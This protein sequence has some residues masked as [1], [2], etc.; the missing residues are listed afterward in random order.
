[1]I[2]V[3]VCGGRR[4]DGVLPVLNSLHTERPI[5]LVVHGGAGQVVDGKTT[6]AD[7][8]A[9]LWARRNQVN[10][11]RVPAKWRKLG[12]PAGMIRNREMLE[13]S[14]SVVVDLVVAF[15]GGV[16]TADMVSRARAAGIHVMEI[17]S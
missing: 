12:R 14:P 6:G 3:L 2:T 15:P 4:Y 8:Q 13:L 17:P 9:G 16:G 10:C 1:M 7:E 11:L 5:G